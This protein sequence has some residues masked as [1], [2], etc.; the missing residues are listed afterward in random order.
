MELTDHH[1][2]LLMICDAV[3]WG[4]EAAFTPYNYQLFRRALGMSDPIISFEA[5]LAANHAEAYGLNPPPSP[6]V[7]PERSPW[8]LTYDIEWWRLEAI[9]LAETDLS[10]LEHQ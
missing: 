5:R 7:G 6:P 8:L 9:D 1:L 4:E 10:Y 2:K 3:R